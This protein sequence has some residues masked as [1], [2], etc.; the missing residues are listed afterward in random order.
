MCYY[1]YVINMKIENIKV[2]YL[3]TNV[4]LLSKNNHYLIIDPGD[5]SKKIINQIKGKVDGIIITHHHFDHVGALDELIDKYHVDIIDFNSEKKQVIDNFKFEIIPTP[6]HT[7]DSVTF[8]FYDDNIMFTGDF[9][10]KD[11]IGRTDLPTGNEIDMFKSLK[12]IKDYSGDIKIYPGHG[13]ET[14]L[15]EEF[16]NNMY[17]NI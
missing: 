6:G 8:Y 3:E 14:T 11:T 16:N 4:Y 9:I 10:F 5:E 1:I 15:K 17:F 2:G 7:N 13:E 12:S